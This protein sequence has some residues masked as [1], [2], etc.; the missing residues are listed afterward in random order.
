[1]SS[2]DRSPRGLLRRGEQGH[3]CLYGPHFGSLWPSSPSPVHAMFSAWSTWKYAGGPGIKGGSMTAC[4]ILTSC[5]LSSRSHSPSEV[6]AQPQA[7][8]MS[9]VLNVKLK[10]IK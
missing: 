10:P 7:S 1:M 2:A 8:R 5:P 3:L 9:T 4:H 6:F